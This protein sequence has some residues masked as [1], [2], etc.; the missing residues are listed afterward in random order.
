[1]WMIS[2]V[3]RHLRRGTEREWKGNERQKGC[4]IMDYELCNGVFYQG[5]LSIL[6]KNYVSACTE[7]MGVFYEMHDIQPMLQW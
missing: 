2:R 5:F 4:V 3:Y 6:F 7:G 1:M